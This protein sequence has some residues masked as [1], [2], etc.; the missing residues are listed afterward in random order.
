MRE[1]MWTSPARKRENLKSEGEW[2]RGN[3]KRGRECGPRET[4][5]EERECN[6]REGTWTSPGAQRGNV[7]LARSKESEG[8]WTSPVREERDELR[9]GRRVG[10]EEGVCTSPAREGQTARETREAEG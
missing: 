2:T 8:M 3:L 9:L 1:G 7:A 4:Q 10:A 6:E 5:M